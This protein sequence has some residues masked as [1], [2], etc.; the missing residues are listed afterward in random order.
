M[1]RIKMKL[2]LFYGGAGAVGYLVGGPWWKSILAGALWAVMFL[3]AEALFS[4]PK[5]KIVVMHGTDIEPGDTICIRDREYTVLA[6]E[7]D[8]IT[9]DR[10]L[11]PEA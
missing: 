4:K 10:P 2:L 9:I 1:D 6:S 8:I 11:E 7:G 5:A 3:A